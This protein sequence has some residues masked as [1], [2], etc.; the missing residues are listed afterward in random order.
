MSKKKDLWMPLYIG[1]YLA[2]T[3]HLTTTQHGAYLLLC[4]HYWRKQGLPDDDKQLAAIA[5]LPLRIWLD[6][7]ETIQAFFHDGWSHKRIDEELHR[8]AVV[9][10]KRAEAGARGGAK[11]RNG[12]NCSDFA[13]GLLE[14]NGSMTQSQSHVDVA[15]DARARPSTGNLT[16]SEAMDLCEKLLAIAGHDPK[17]WPPG[18]CGAPLT[19]QKWLNGGWQPEIILAAVKSAAGRKRGAPANSVQFF[20]NAIAEEHA[21]QAAPLPVVEIKQAQTLTVTHGNAQIR[22]GGSLTD[23]IKRELAELEGSESTD[24]ALSARPVLRLSS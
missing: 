12:S 21:R 24:L 11:P 19:V 23:S 10:N 13:S 9:S 6:M 5:K 7:K 16:T 18:W 17:F 8:R 1:D 14:Q 22:S 4:M 2:D 15:D 3:G 20:E